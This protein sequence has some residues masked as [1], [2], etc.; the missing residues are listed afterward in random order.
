MFVLLATRSSTIIM[1]ILLFD[2]KGNQLSLWNSICSAFIYNIY[3]NTRTSNPRPT[4]GTH[5]GI[6]GAFFL[7]ILQT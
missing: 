4:H 6:T 2:P 1:V 3:L 5:A 7:H